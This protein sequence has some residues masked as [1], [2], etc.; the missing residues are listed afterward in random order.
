MS[1]PTIT[2]GILTGYERTGWIHPSIFSYWEICRRLEAAGQLPF[3][4]NFQPLHGNGSATYK[5]NLISKYFKESSPSSWGEWLC[6]IDNDMELPSNFMEAVLRAPEDASIV[7]PRMYFWDATQGRETTTLCWGISQNPTPELFM[8]I[9]SNKQGYTRLIKC[10]TGAIFIH[11]RVFDKIQLPY[12]KRLVDPVT[13]QETSTEDIYFSLKVKEAG[14]KVYGCNS[15][16]VGHYHNVNLS[17]VAKRFYEDR[18][19]TSG[20]GPEESE[21]QTLDTGVTINSSSDKECPSE[22]DV[23]AVSPTC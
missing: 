7:C 12:F 9:Y 14:L 10:G 5:R 17:T 19:L 3:S 13:D 15:V 1:K 4:V 18:V 8:R 6:M 11:R 20:L 23:A 2:V 16:E 22:S 21:K